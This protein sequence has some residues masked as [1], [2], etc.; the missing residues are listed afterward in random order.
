ML[1]IEGKRTVLRQI[2]ESDLLTL[3]EWRNSPSYMG[4]C[5]TRR[6][7]VSLCEFR[8][9]IAKDFSRDR[10]LQCI[11]SRKNEA[12]GTIYAYGLNRSDGHVFVTTYVKPGYEKSGSGAEAFILFVYHLFESLSL[13]KVYSEVYSYNQHSLSCLKNGGFI[14]EGRFVGHRLHAGQR[15]DLVRLSLFRERVA[16]WKGV[17]SNLLRQ[18]KGGEISGQSRSKL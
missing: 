17:V 14:E 5:S 1:L 11:I 6:N 2:D 3:H 15:F 10:Y 16:Q 12:I 13:Y 9:E 18:T 8:R 4:L 7:T